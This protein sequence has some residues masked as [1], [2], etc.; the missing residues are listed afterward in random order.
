MA[1]PER[2]VITYD[3]RGLGR[4]TRDDGRTVNDP[5]V[6]ADD[7]HALIGALGS[8]PVE[9]FAS[10]GCGHR[11]GPGRRAPRGRSQLHDVLDTP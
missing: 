2:T 1:F 3:P 11:P 10:S 9:L 7:L 5:G 4:S 8:G 6:Q